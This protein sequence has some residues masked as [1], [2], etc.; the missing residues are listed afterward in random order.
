MESSLHNVPETDI[1]LIC[2][3]FIVMAAT[4]GDNCSRPI[5]IWRLRYS[6]FGMIVGESFISW[7]PSFK[8]V[9]G[10]KIHLVYRLV[11]QQVIGHFLHSSA[12]IV[13]V[14]KIIIRHHQ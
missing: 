9:Q 11:T 4:G 5:H 3:F 8:Q 12:K 10:I 14:S 7:V 6:R 2:Q 13:G 1:I